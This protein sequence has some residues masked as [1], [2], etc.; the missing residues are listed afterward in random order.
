MQLAAIALGLVLVSN[1]KMVTVV[2]FCLMEGD[3]D[4]LMHKRVIWVVHGR[5]FE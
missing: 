5:G 4:W 1:S 2:T 3:S